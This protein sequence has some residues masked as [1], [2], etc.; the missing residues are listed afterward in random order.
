MKLLWVA[1]VVLLIDQA[2]KVAVRLNMAME[3]YRSI[4]LLGDWLKFTYTENPGMAFGITFGP[5]GL[6]TGFSIIATMLIIVYMYRVRGGYAPYRFSLAFILG[7]AIG[8][9]IDRLF[10]GMI[11][12]YGEFFKGR[13]VDF[14][15]V[16]AWS[17]FIP[18]AVPL[19]GG[20]YMALFPIF[21]IA[22]VAIVGGVV[23]I[24]VF[25]KKFHQQ[26]IDAAEAAR[27][28]S[29][30]GAASATPAVATA[31]ATDPAVNGMPPVG[32]APVVE[33]PP[34]VETPPVIGTPPSVGEEKPEE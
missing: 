25:Q 1:S 28:S 4:P 24:L 34:V 6:I 31:A 23:G 14:I 13:V 8:N 26:L 12:G 19:M 3:P 22:D 30:E 15:H 27:A 16:N 20:T 29:S 33:P 10:Y 32:E 21:N 17:G 2:T 5:A 11:F 7:G 9:I 18:D